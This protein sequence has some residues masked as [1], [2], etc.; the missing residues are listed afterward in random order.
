MNEAKHEPLRSSDCLVIALEETRFMMTVTSKTKSPHRSD[1][2]HG[3]DSPQSERSL[4]SGDCDRSDD[5]SAFWDVDVEP[6][7][8]APLPAAAKEGHS[9][10]DVLAEELLQR[11]IPEYLEQF[12]I[13]VPDAEIV[14]GSVPVAEV[15]Q[16]E[17]D[18]EDAKLRRAALESEQYREREARLAK[19]EAAARARLLR[20]ATKRHEALERDKLQQVH[21]LQLRA[22][23]LKYVFQQAENHLKDELRRQQAHVQRVYGDLVPSRVPH[24]RKRYR[25]EWQSVPLTLKIRVKMLSAL[26]DKLPGGHYVLVATVYDRLGGHALHWS[27]WDPE[28]DARR[29]AS[30]SVGSQTLLGRPNFTRPF[31]HRG[32]F[33]NTEVAVNQS[34]YVVC[35]P[36]RA[37]RPGNVLIFELF[38]LAPARSQSSH[39]R[40]RQQRTQQQLDD[41]VVAWGAMPLTTP[42]SQCLRG[43]FKV[44]LLRG[45]MDPTMDKFGD[46]ERTY[47]SDLSSW[48]CNLYF[49]ASHLEKRLPRPRGADFDVEIDES[50]GLFRVENTH[51]R[52][53]RRLTTAALTLGTSKI[54][55]EESRGDEAPND[56]DT[57]RQAD[58]GT[59]S[60]RHRTRSGRGALASVGEDERYAAAAAGGGAALYPSSRTL[61]LDPSDGTDDVK[62]KTTSS[63]Q[64][65]QRLLAPMLSTVR[66]TWKRLTSPSKTRVYSGEMVDEMKRQ[67]AAPAAHEALGDSDAGQPTPPCCRTTRA[68]SDSDDDETDG[69]EASDSGDGAGRGLADTESYKFSVNDAACVETARHKR[70]H[71]Q[72]KLHY[73]RHELLAD[74]G[75]SNLRTL[76]FWRFAALLLLALWARVYVHYLAQWL[77]LRGSRVPVFD[78]QP[79][80]ATCFV[81]YTARSLATRTEIGVIVGGALGNVAVF[82][83]LALAAAVAQRVVGE[84]PQVASVCIVC[85]ALAAVLDPY[86]VFL[87]DVARRHYDC[88]DSSTNC[89]A[90]L[91]ARDC[92]CVVGDAFKLYARFLAQ[93]GSGVV[94]VVLTVFL[95]A[96]LTSLSLVC[97]YAYLLHVHMNGRMLDVYRRVHGQECDFF[98]PHD[99]EVGLAD[100]RAICEH[101]R[102]WKGPRGTQRK[103]FVHEY[104]LADPLD[105]AFTEK[106]VYVAV[107]NMELDGTR[108][109]HRHF[110]KADDGAILE[111]FGEVGGRGGAWLH[112]AHSAASL[113]LLSTILQDHRTPEGDGGATP[114][115]LTA[116]FDGL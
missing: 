56:S 13:V 95:Y 116:L 15:E 33:Y 109:L 27:A 45:E 39:A 44:P 8:L 100:L 38:L 101:A 86:L 53:M 42:E 68:P 35:P 59:R 83:F 46:I 7:A 74:V 25:A 60:R 61:L 111:L 2:S 115:R 63:S 105:P 37:L 16:R 19:Q 21:A 51:Q 107:Y 43:K 96:A 5:D 110:L 71:T 48:L 77:F 23:R 14:V 84:L 69:K 3:F 90:S 94:G 113:A 9:I 12:E 97:V 57:Q 26:K 78:F 66:R 72:R 50:S 24:S 93:E 103:V 47:E 87:V 75:A 54:V 22:H 76:D 55:Q 10:I 114:E 98:V 62:R 4:Q 112:G 20:E 73:L 17:Q 18:V 58:T 108:E 79:H 89:A 65:T 32:R 92:Q 36:E 29:A 88:A 30:A 91:S 40:R 31:F 81:K 6:S 99:G 34:M 11:E 64:A 52:Y 70:F 85:V 104:A 49:V 82:G 106:S 28:Y 80:W 102:R 41:Q 1:R 67:Q